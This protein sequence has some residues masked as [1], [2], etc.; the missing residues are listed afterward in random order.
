LY[1]I[2][3]LESKSRIKFFG[4]LLV[5]SI[6]SWVTKHPGFAYHVI[7]GIVHMT[8][9]PGFDLRVVHDKILEVIMIATI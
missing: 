8:V 9:G 5:A 3:Y 1:F 4:P 6:T 7:Y 2:S